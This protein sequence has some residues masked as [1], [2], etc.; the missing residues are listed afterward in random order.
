MARILTESIYG[1]KIDSTGKI[2]SFSRYGFEQKI[3]GRKDCFICGARQDG[4]K[5]FNEEHI[6]P[7]W[8]ISKYSSPKKLVGL[9]NLTKYRLNQ[10]KVPCCK[11][12]NQRMGKEIEQPVS[13]LF[14][15]SHQEFFNKITQNQD[16]HLLLYRWMCLI[17]F[18]IFYKDTFLK[19]DRSDP[20][21]DARIGDIYDWH[22]IHFIH[23]IARSHYSGLE[24]QPNVV[25]S[26]LI[27]SAL[28]ISLDKGG[29]F[30]TY[31][32]NPCLKIN[33]NGICVI[34][35]LMDAGFFDHNFFSSLFS[36]FNHQ[37]SVDQLTE[38]M[39][40]LIY[41]NTRLKENP[42][43]WF[44]HS[45]S[46]RVQAELPKAVVLNEVEK[47]TKEEIHYRLVEG[48]LRRNNPGP[49]TEALL[50][51]IRREGGSTLYDEN[52]KP[53]DISKITRKER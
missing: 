5:K 15:L 20:N 16:N 51:R 37:L 32:N 40:F 27:L 24:I 18:K 3:I 9:P 22:N 45:P 50:D 1:D 6:I 29:I 34:M 23:N 8:V 17:Y 44:K 39:A 21:S 14:E 43:F 38:I 41:G 46:F 4:Y 11:E 36:D 12:C 19:A 13:R 26:T 25:G 31:Y 35:M 47:Y 42:V 33:I 2:I 48:P 28:P 30:L 53:V 49:E 52:G 7:D 10:Y